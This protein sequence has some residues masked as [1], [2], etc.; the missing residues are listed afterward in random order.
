MKCQTAFF[1]SLTLVAATAQAQ[2]ERD[3]AVLKDKQT[4]AQ[5]D[6]WFYDDVEPAF[7]VAARTKRPLM[8]VFR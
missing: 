5:E 1:F 2:N 3:I 4:L 7:E 6:F 8:I